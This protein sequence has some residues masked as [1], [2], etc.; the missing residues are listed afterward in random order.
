MYQDAAVDGYK[1]HMNDISASILLA[2][3]EYAV[4]RHKKTQD[5]VRLLS[6]RVPNVLRTSD[7]ASYW[8]AS[9]FFRDPMAMKQILA[10]NGFASDQVHRRNDEMKIFKER[11][12]LRPLP[13]TDDFYRHML[14]V[15]VGWW[16]SGGDI[17]RMSNLIKEYDVVTVHTQERDFSQEDREGR[18]TDF[19]GS[20]A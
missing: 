1:F 5:N 2:N 6:G 7:Y 9:C 13:G 12:I 15:P 8:I 4:E 10:E 18:P 14:C 20:Q 16:V 17:V 11:A 3:Y 19:V